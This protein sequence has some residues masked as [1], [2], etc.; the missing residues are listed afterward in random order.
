MR[1]VALAGGVGR[2]EDDGTVALL[3]APA[4][5]GD[6]IA[7]GERPASIGR[8][9]VT[10]RTT[11]DQ[12]AL[13]LPV[14]SGATVFGVGMNYASKQAV[15]GRPKPE[16]PTWFAKCPSAFVAPGAPILLPPSAPDCVDY[17]GELAV[18]LGAP[19][20]EATPAEA[21]AAISAV[22]AADDVTARDVMRATGNPMLA[23]SYPGFGQLGSCVLDPLEHG[24]V[25]GLEIATTVNG[26]P[27]QADRGD[28]MLD[29]VVT[30]L[31]M[32]SRH[33]LLRPG[34][35]LLTG[36]PAGTGDETGTYLVPGDVVEVTASGLPPLRSL[37]EAA[38]AA[39]AAGGPA[40]IYPN[41][42]NR[43]AA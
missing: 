37:V 16:R 23:K 4:R 32:L 22:A 19:L 18:L 26:Q 42:D 7:S 5:L 12:A 29:D 31:V 14:P 24:G 39:G 36:T 21:A 41:A 43:G 6:L 27:R 15:T 35:V 8:L 33:A 28:G 30:L 34:D 25:A 20:F 9:A 38:G 40:A 10:G 17:E 13:A 1:L 3:G 11:I 2:I